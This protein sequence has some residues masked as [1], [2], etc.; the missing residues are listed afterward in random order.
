MIERQP[1]V[2]NRQKS[3]ACL[4]PWIHLHVG[5]E[6]VVKACCVANIPFGNINDDSLTKIWNSQAIRTL[7]NKFRRGEKDNRCVVC[8]QAEAADATSL[9]QETNEKY[10]HLLHRIE[11]TEEDGT[12]ASLPVYFDVR[13]SN[14]CNF[15]CRTCWHGASSK[16]FEEAKQLGN[17]VGEK[18]LILNV[19]NFADF[20]EKIK[21]A[22]EGL[23]EIYF[24][25]G[26]PLVTEEHY[27]LLDWLIS[28]KL[29]KVKLRY[30]TNFSILTYKQRNIIS[31]WQQFNKVEVMASI[32]GTKE[33]GEYIRKE[34]NW[35]QFEENRKQLVTVPHVDF[36][37]APTVSI[38]NIA[39]LPALYNYCVAQKIIGPEGIYFNLLERPH[40]YNIKTLPLHKKEEVSAIYKV[41]L[42]QEL[43]TQVRK[44]F[45]ECLQFMLVEDLSNKWT[46]FKQESKKL[47]SI[48]GE[49]L[50]EIIPFLANS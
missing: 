37:I 14:I 7:R 9:R 41:F 32:D 25:G 22:G 38:F 23:E 2:K 44:G 42:G 3:D 4:M 31:Y 21:Q 15:R 20:L 24:A 12:V 45:E 13:F 1:I 48:R 29:T 43:P 16:W 49:N 11:E 27:Q 36:K 34:M 18:T 8:H 35:H 40:H 46:K 47:D 5:N 33:I 17:T 26:E 50:Q 6:G 39:H 28:K 10:K 19:K 30:N